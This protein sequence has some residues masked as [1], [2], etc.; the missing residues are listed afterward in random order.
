MVDDKAIQ[1]TEA[2]ITVEVVII[3]AGAVGLSLAIALGQAG[4]NVA[5][6]S[7]QPMSC[8]FSEQQAYD[9][10][11]VALNWASQTLLQQLQIWPQIQR[12]ASYTKMQVWDSE[13]EGAITFD[14]VHLPQQQLGH[15]VEQSVL[16]S[17]LTTQLLSLPN[18]SF[19]E[20][21]TAQDITQCPEHITVRCTNGHCI[22][23]KLL[24]GADGKNSWVRQQQGIKVTGW[25][26]QQQALIATIK[27]SKPHQGTAFQRF[28]ADG[29]LALLPLADPYFC[30]IVWSTSPSHAQRL[31]Q[32]PMVA[33]EQQ[34]ALATEH[35]LG[36][37]QL[38]SKRVGFPLALQNAQHYCQARCVLVGDAAHTIHPLAGLGMNL[39]LLDMATLSELL[40]GAKQAGRDIGQLRLLRKYARARSAHLWS[41]AAAMEGF[42]QGFGSSWLS[43]KWLRNQ[44]LNWVNRNAGLKLLC[45]DA[46][47]GKIGYQLPA[48]L[49][50]P[51]ND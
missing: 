10:R 8:Q 30:S 36:T 50:T 17:S 28:A 22:Q 5:I 35:V 31:Q 42:K 7:A 2:A 21:T 45:I 32:L 3:G 43:I 41:V 23:A 16:L 20:N 18:V 48:I 19:Y 6:V 44:G 33:F 51:P 9:L 40:I 27:T 47:M 49:L 26:Y 25:D 37:L 39:G 13:G 12:L 46:A 4:F 11:V 38:K 15:I 24:V 14:S 1:A 34:L 29:A